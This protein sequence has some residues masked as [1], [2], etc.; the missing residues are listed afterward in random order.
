[1][2]RLAGAGVWQCWL[3]SPPAAGEREQAGRGSRDEARHLPEELEVR[4]AAAR[5]PDRRGRLLPDLAAE[6]ADGKMGGQ[7][8]NSE[9]VDKDSSYL[10]SFVWQEPP[11]QRRATSTCAATPG[12]RRSRPARTPVVG[13]KVARATMPCFTDPHGKRR[14][15]GSRRRCTRSTRAPTSGTSSTRG[16][17]TGLY[18]VSEHVIRR[19]ATEGREQPRPMIRGLV[20]VEPASLSMKLTRK[21]VLGGAAGAAL[22]AAGDLRARRPARRRAAGPR[23]AGRGPE[24]HLLDGV[25][26]V[27]RNGVEVVV[28]PLHHQIVTAT[29]RRAAG[30]LAEAQASSRR[31]GGARSRLPARRPRGSASRWRGAG[32][33]STLR[34]GGRDGTCHATAGRAR[35]RCSTRSV[36]RATPTR[37]CSSRTTSPSSCA[38]TRARTSGRRRTE[39]DDG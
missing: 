36:F 20:L 21:Q 35:A 38:A 29:R 22:G 14:S 27:S 28:P 1:M 3:S 9:S 18:T 39:I 5:E 15:A 7:W 17:T 11:S 23:G 6:P 25:R 30:R 24:Q 32:R 10:E 19:S 33:T 26:V 16:T 2:L 8:N 4:L 37:R 31:A 34:R 13:G 12:G